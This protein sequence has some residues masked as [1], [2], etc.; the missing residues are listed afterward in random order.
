MN[1]LKKQSSVVLGSWIFYL[2]TVE[3]ITN[4]KLDK[5]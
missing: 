2:Q 4:N 5:R 3:E 1:Y